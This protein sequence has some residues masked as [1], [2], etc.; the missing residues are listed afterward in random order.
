M[1]SMR[2]SEAP[3]PG[4][5]PGEATHSKGLSAIAESPFEFYIFLKDH[6]S[7]NTTFFTLSF[8]FTTLK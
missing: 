4:S 6:Y 1:D 3:D 5:I 2:V 7:F 8:P